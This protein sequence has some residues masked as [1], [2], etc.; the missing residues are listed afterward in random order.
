[1]LIRRDPFVA[2]WSPLVGESSAQLYWLS[3]RLQGI[4]ALLIPTWALLFTFGHRQVYLIAG[5][6]LVVVDVAV[7]VSRCLVSGRMYRHMTKR[8]GMRVNWGNAP[9][10]A[11]P[12]FRRWCGRHGINHEYGLPVSPSPGH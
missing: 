1:V 6:V 8:F 2:K 7:F 11:E 10:L 12:S 9:M 3:T 5:V 4:A